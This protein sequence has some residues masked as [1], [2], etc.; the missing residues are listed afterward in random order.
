MS[1][2]MT[3]QCQGQ[4]SSPLDTQA[5]ANR[6]PLLPMTLRLVRGAA[7][8]LVVF[9]AAVSHAQT[10][11]SNVALASAGG[12]ATASSTLSSG[13]PVTSVNNDERTG[14]NYSNGLSWVDATPNVYPDWV[15]INFSG[16][17]TIDRVVLYTMQDNYTNP[18]EPTDTLTFSVYGVTGFTVQTW[19]GA[20]WV[21]QATV[22]GNNLV[23]RSVTF[24]PVIT[25]RMRLNVT[26]TPTGYSYITEIEAWT[27]S[28]PDVTPPSV[29]TGLAANPVSSSQVNLSWTAST[30]NVGVTG[31][32]VYR[33][34]VLMASQAG[35]SYSDT[36][37][38]ATTLYSYTVAACDAASNCSAQSDAITAT[39]SAS[40][41][42]ALASAGGIATASSTLSYHVVTSVNNDERTGGNYSSG[43]SWV[44]AT[45]NVYPDWVQ[46]NFSGAQ[47]ID[48]VVLYTMQDNYTNP[49]EPTDTLTFSVY[50]VTGF[51]VQTWD[52]AAWVT[53]ATVTGNN[54]VKRSVAFAPVT[55]DRMRLNVTNTPTGYSYITEIAAWTP[56]VDIAPSTIAK[57][58]APASITAGGTSTLTFALSNSNAIAL[59]NATFTDTLANMS[60]SS[61]AIGGTCAGVTSS[62]ALAVGA[63]LLNLTIPNLSV[64]SC[65]VTVQVTSST[66]GT[67]PN[68][69]SGV[70]STQTLTAGAVSNTANLTVAAVIVAPTIATSFAP[71]AIM[72]GGTSII[73]FTLGNL[74]ASALTNANFTDTLANMSLSSATIGG[75]CAG[76]TNSPTLVIGATSLNLTVPSL[77]VGGCTVS[78][79]VTSSVVGTNPNTASGVTSAQTPAAGAASNTANLTVTAV[80][81]PTI[82]K[83]FAPASITVAGTSTITFT[84]GNANA[85]ALTNANFTDTL[86][87][88]SLSSTAIGG[89]CAG[90]SNSPALAVGATSLNLTVPSLPAGGCTV[91]VE[92]TSSTLG[93]SPNTASGVTSTQ[94]P[95]AGAASNTAN[96]TVGDPGFFYVHADQLGTPRAI[97][98]PSDNA[99]V[100]EWANSEPFGNNGP[101]ESPS[102]LGTFTYNLRFPGQYF[103][104]ET[105]TH[106]N[107]FRDYDPGVG[108]YIESDPIGLG[109]GI[110]TF[111]YV[112]GNPLILSDPA[113]LATY[114]CTRRLNN[115]PF[116][117]G[118][119]YH[120]YVCIGNPKDGYTCGGIGPS[121][122]MFDSPSVLE[123]DSMRPDLCEKTQDDDT[124]VE[125]CIAKRFKGPLPNYSVNLK[126]GENCQTYAY[127]TELSCVAECKLKKRK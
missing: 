15:Q 10:P 120:Q 2:A 62:P 50:G 103:D 67:N 16:A 68:T 72:A 64:G 124:C 38:A 65:T 97:T 7:V 63:T 89:T 54:L 123:K 98:R 53:Q 9:V 74:N 79:Q 80:I 70:T 106:Y 45:P 105:G 76:V 55:T 26:N 41:N 18:I 32:K 23:K 24:A 111:G 122:S 108:R 34:G 118:P 91:T 1:A 49:I 22:T 25:D 40:S 11:A 127:G 51:T 43:L 109:G 61:T 4:T 95:T 115:V 20:A 82:A 17:N 35:T 60:V 21:T 39:T 12:V 8:A 28:P 99:V 58:F 3:N 121:G 85:A 47:T 100:W 119:L 52:G 36:G 125:E 113:G 92:V 46:I 104:T 126:K 27:P 44:D 19:D 81:A 56:A 71:T 117:V 5:R 42:V 13:H 86:A 73:T 102:A 84:L 90:V 112:Q 116:R 14:G 101:N 87:N 29:P 96:L 77:P 114:Q 31:Y 30:D 94:M 57:S 69:A 59:T 107:R 48:R 6:S 110:N 33:G 88:M 78:V 37:L 93:T 75:T 66:V 83:G